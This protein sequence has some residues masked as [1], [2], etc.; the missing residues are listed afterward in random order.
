MYT[1]RTFQISISFLSF[2]LLSIKTGWDVYLMLSKDR[3][4]G[5]QECMYAQVIH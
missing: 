1:F 4:G 3:L 2:P 5:I